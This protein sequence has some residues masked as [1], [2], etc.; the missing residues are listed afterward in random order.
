MPMTKTSLRQA[1]WVLYD[2]ASSGYVLLITAVAFPLYFKLFVAAN[3]T[4]SEALWGLMLAFSSIT[5]GLLAP[6]IG[7]AA[8]R[9]GRRLR[10]LAIATICCSL[11]TIALAAPGAGIF[12]AGICFCISYV[13]Y[14]VAASLYDSLM[15]NLAPIGR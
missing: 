11:A 9:S 8:D 2:I 4:W 15:K 1:F 3:A 12:F 6:I 14:L 5:A 13:A 10:F 7:A